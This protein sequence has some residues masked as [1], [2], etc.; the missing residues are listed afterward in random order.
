MIR[1]YSDYSSWQVGLRRSNGARTMY[2]KLS[3]DGIDYLLDP[4][5]AIAMS[6]RLV[7]ASEEAE[8]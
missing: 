2:V 1:Q 4:A 7:D 3:I 5:D 6:N 8:R